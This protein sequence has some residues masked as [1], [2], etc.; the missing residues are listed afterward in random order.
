MN[1]WTFILLLAVVY[2]GWKHEVLPRWRKNHQQQ[3]SSGSQSQESSA[4]NPQSQSK[5]RRGRVRQRSQQGAQAVRKQTRRGGRAVAK[6]AGKAPR[7]G[8]KP[9]LAVL[10][11]VAL[12]TSNIVTGW[13]AWQ[14]NQENDELSERIADLEDQIRDG[15]DADDVDDEVVQTSASASGTEECTTNVHFF[16]RDMDNN[17]FGPEVDVRT[18]QAAIKELESR[19]CKDPALLAAVN[20]YLDVNDTGYGTESQV[21]QAHAY[22][23]DRELWRSDVDALMFQSVADL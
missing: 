3:S 2:L 23:D 4:D 19:V 13:V 16:A 18:H 20:S 6:V 8:W 12:V 14:A 10:L 17:F 7:P 15:G 5:S 9:T 21:A 1:G 11:A 22:L